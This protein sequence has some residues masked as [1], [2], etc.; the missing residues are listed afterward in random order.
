MHKTVMTG[1]PVY[2]TPHPKTLDYTPRSPPDRLGRRLDQ[3]M[4]PVTGSATTFGLQPGLL[5]RRKGEVG[6]KK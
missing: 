2:Y 3:S 1:K 6:P 5:P 4:G